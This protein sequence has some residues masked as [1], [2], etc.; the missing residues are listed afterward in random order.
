MPAGRDRLRQRRRL[1]HAVHLPD[2]H[3]LS[4]CGA[5]RGPLLLLAAG[6]A[7]RLDRRR[8]R[9]AVQRGDRR[10]GVQQFRRHARL[11][12]RP[13]PA[14]R[15]EHRRCRPQRLVLLRPAARQPGR[16][17]Q[18]PERRPVVQDHLNRRAVLLLGRRAQCR[19]RQQQLH[20]VAL[21]RHRRQAQRRVLVLRRLYPD[22]LDRRGERRQVALRRPHLGRRDPVALPG[23]R[24]AGQPVGRGRPDPGRHR[25]RVH[26]RRDSG[27]SNWPVRARPRQG[28]LH[29][30][31]PTP[32]T[33]R[34]PRPRSSPPRCRPPR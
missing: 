32:W 10:R 26:R 29:R 14:R 22:H 3:G 28:R 7:V 21:H 34:W 33:A 1:L 31:S 30:A 27:A 19:H 18:L 24:A 20:A 13:R 5:R 11:V 8:V 23:R 6:R 9:G 15:R 4:G 17:L 12:F 2:R 25:A 16:L